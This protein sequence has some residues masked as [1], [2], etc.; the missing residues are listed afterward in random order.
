MILHVFCRMTSKDTLNK[1]R[2]MISPSF[3][4]LAEN[5]LE[6]M[7]PINPFVGPP[8]NHWSPLWTPGAL[9][10][11]LVSWALTLL[12]IRMLLANQTLFNP[13]CYHFFFQP[14]FYT[15]IRMYLFN[16]CVPFS[17]EL[18][19]SPKNQHIHDFHIDDIHDQHSQEFATT[20]FLLYAQITYCLLVVCALTQTHLQA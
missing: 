17:A 10:L 16:E 2:G 20:H 8:L 19:H 13:R 11:L 4:K 18:V 12:T 7:I 15:F 14:I 5:N 1:S 3:S 9:L 6:E